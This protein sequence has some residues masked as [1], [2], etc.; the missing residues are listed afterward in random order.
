MKKIGIFAVGL[1]VTT[2]Y[3]EFAKAEKTYKL[4]VECKTTFEEEKLDDFTLTP[5]PPENSGSCEPTNISGPMTEMESCAVDVKPTYKSSARRG[6]YNITFKNPVES[7]EK[8]GLTIKYDMSSKTPVDVTTNFTDK[9]GEE[10]EPASC[11][12]SLTELK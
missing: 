7:K 12:Y 11:S 8:L 9:D 5:H 3:M 4:E 10:D 2:G 1:L 6:E